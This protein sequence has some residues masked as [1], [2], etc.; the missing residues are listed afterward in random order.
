MDQ[1]IALLFD[2]SDLL[3]ITGS[4]FNQGARL[5]GSGGFDLFRSRD[6]MFNGLDPLNFE[7]F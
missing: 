4:T 2:G 3:E 5:D 7:A 1:F 6:N